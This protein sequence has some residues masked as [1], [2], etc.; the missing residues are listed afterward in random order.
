MVGRRWTSE[1]GA[2]DDELVEAVDGTIDHRADGSLETA[3]AEIAPP[4][5][6]NSSHCDSYYPFRSSHRRSVRHAAL[7]QSVEYAEE[8]ARRTRAVPTYPTPADYS[9]CSF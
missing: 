3:A 2:V 4:V 5:N 8:C 6:N 1:A 7:R 9:Q